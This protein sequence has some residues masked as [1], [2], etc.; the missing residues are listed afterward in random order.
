MPTPLTK[1]GIY[2]LKNAGNLKEKITVPNSISDHQ[3]LKFTKEILNPEY[4]E[5][6]QK[7]NQAQYIAIKA[8]IF[9]TKL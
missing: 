4:E 8:N 3:I 9:I 1:I 7:Y 5:I 2:H 6:T